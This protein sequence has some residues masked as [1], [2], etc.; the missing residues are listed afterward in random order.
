MLSL[1]VA[2]EVLRA[3]LSASAL[4]T[5]SAIDILWDTVLAKFS[6]LQEDRLRRHGLQ[7]VRCA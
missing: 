6:E 4:R 3:R 2:G 5:D 7:G 1:W